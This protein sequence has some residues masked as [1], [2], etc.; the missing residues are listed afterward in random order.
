MIVSFTCLENNQWKIVSVFDI[1]V[2][3]T[4]FSKAIKALFRN[5]FT[6]I[7]FCLLLENALH[8]CLSFC[9]SVCLLS[10]WSKMPSLINRNKLIKFQ[11]PKF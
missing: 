7:S 9:S 10:Q 2:I 8:S 3:W 11:I 6:P 5:D 4:A 1:S